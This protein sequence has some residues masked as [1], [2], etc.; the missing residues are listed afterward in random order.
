MHAQDRLGRG[1][2]RLR[3]TQCSG[4]LFV[5]PAGVEHRSVAA[6]ETE[7][8]VMHAA[9]TVPPSGRAED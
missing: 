4:Q 7:V 5:V 9:T 3:A 2:R 1:L 6:D 8:I